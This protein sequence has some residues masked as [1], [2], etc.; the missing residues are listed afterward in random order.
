MYDGIISDTNVMY[1]SVISVIKNDLKFYKILFT[2]EYSHGI[3]YT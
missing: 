1:Y 3:L 2:N